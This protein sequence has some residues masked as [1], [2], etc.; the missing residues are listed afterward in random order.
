MSDV[1]AAS[2]EGTEATVSVTEALA[3]TAITG[4]DNVAATEASDVKQDNNELVCDH[5][6]RTKPTK[7][8]LHEYCFH[9]SMRIIQEFTI[10]YGR[11]NSFI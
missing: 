7:E 6:K 3:A 1:T 10:W 2:K 4:E 5:C 8:I 9:N 11:Q